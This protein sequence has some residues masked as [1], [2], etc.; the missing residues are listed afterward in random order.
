MFLLSTTKSGSE[1]DGHITFCNLPGRTHA[2]DRD[3]RCHHDNQIKQ[4]ECTPKYFYSSCLSLFSSSMSP[5]PAGQENKSKH[6]KL[7]TK[8]KGDSREDATMTTKSNKNISSSCLSHSSSFMAPPTPPGGRTTNQSIKVR[9]SK[10]GRK[11]LPREPNRT[12]I[13]FF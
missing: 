10:K 3:G 9:N 13:L 5:T 6:Q 2:N 11:I 8:K 4:G 12:T 1:H 7:E